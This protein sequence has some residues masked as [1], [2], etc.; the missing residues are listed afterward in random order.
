MIR[1]LILQRICGTKEQKRKELIFVDV[2]SVL[3]TGRSSGVIKLSYPQEVF[4]IGT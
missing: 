2:Y 1:L 3:G 4:I